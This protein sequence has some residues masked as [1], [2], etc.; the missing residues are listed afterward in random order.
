MKEVRLIGLIGLKQ[1]GK[2]TVADILVEKNGFVKEAFAGRLKQI[3]MENFDLSPAQVHGEFK[4]MPDPR[5]KSASGEPRT[6]RFILQFMG[7]QAFRKVDPDFWVKYFFAHTYDEERMYVISDVRFPNEMDAIQKRGGD[8]WVVDMPNKPQRLTLWQKLRHWVLRTGPYHASEKMAWEL[9]RKG[10]KGR[11]PHNIPYVDLL[12]GHPH[13]N[14]RAVDRAWQQ[15]EA[16]PCHPADCDPYC[17]GPG[18]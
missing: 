13:A 3:C 7:T 10:R 11:L 9:V 4:E 12:Y 5:W 8:C 6:A 18:A 16:R 14:P 2:D 15:S 17:P 1:H